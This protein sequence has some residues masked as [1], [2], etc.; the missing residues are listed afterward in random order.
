MHFYSE[1]QWF[2]ISKGCK[3]GTA[4]SPKC[5]DYKAER[6]YLGRK[7][8]IS[9]ES[10]CILLS[11]SVI[12]CNL[13]TRH[14]QPLESFLE[15]KTFSD[16]TPDSASIPIFIHSVHLQTITLLLILNKTAPTKSP[17]FVIWLPRS[18]QVTSAAIG[19]S[20]SGQERHLTPPLKHS[21][22]ET[23][24]PPG[25]SRHTPLWVKEST[26]IHHGRADAIA[27]LWVTGRNTQD[28]ECCFIITSCT[29]MV[30][31]HQVLMIP[32]LS[33]SPEI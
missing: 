23:Q 22:L 26:Y 16:E 12:L 10:S 13:N 7:S 2:L 18:P 1:Y 6:S 28:I 3:K 15:S 25:C 21:L 27:F 33:R 32:I 20:F 19:Q 14:T 5:E 31:S 30:L 29:F 4:Y 11:F 9:R 8:L 17:V 24:F